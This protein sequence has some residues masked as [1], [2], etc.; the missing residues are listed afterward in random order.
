MALLDG[1]LNPIGGV[2]GGLLGGGSGGSGN[3]NGGGLLAPITGIV[4]G[5]SGGGSGSGSGTGLL[6]PILNSNGLLDGLIDV[7]LLDQDAL[8]RLDLLPQVNGDG[9]LSLSLLD[10]DGDGLIDVSLLNKAIDI[11]ILDPDGGLIGIDILDTITIDLDLDG[12]RDNNGVPDNSTN[13]DDF[14]VVIIGTDATD[15][16]TISLDQTT[17]FDG[18][19]ATDFAIYTASATQFA[20]AV[21]S[22][23][24]FIANDQK[25]D[26][27]LDVER[28]VF[29]DGTLHIDTGAGE[30]SGFAYRIYQAAFDRAPDAGGLDYWIDV[31]DSGAKDAF[32]VAADFL[33]SVEFQRTYGQLSNQAFIEELY[34]NILQR[35]G[36][37]AGIRFWVNELDSGS[38]DRAEALVGFTESAENIGLV[39]QVIEDGFFLST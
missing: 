5:G 3:T 4:G 29:S 35:D 13:P 37:A 32:D 10:K 23:G 30:T 31:L 36:D 17:Y 25:V 22:N 19:G 21:G 28:V 9:L 26:Y 8:L 18:R 38:R 12:D 6:G 27:L 16:E 7:R 20:Y 1:L 2:V 15:R 11:S 33:Y 39:G 14:D 34:E 24:I